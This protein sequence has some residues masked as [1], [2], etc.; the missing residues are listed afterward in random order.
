MGLLG[1]VYLAAF[2]SRLMSTSSMRRPSRDQRQVRGQLNLHLRPLS[3]SSSRIKHHADRFLQ[4]LPLLLY[5]EGLSFHSDHVEQVPDQ[6]VHPL[7]FFE[8]SSAAD[9]DGPHRAAIDPATGCLR[10][11]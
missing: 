9:P 3:C 2:S 11:Q 7:S 8:R 6:P 10:P 5:H 1:G 4:G